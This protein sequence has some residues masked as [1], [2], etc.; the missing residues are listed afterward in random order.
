[1]RTLVNGEKGDE[2]VATGD[3]YTD[4][5]LRGRWRRIMRAG[6][7]AVML[8]QGEERVAWRMHGTC[9]DVYP[10]VF[11]AELM[12]VLNVLRVA[13]PPLKIHV[14]NAEVVSGFQRGEEWCLAPERDGC[15]L[16]KEVW[17]RMR[18]MDGEVEV[19]KVKAHTAEEEVGE[20]VITAR[21][22]YG[23]LHADAE[24][25]RGAR[26]AES[27]SP[28]GAARS[29]FLKAVR[30]L[31]WVRRYA[32][33]WKEDARE[34]EEERMVKGRVGEGQSELR[35]GAGLRHLVWEKGLALTCRRCGRVADTDQKRRDLRSSRCQ[36][37]AVGRL[38]E[39]TCHDV[40]AVER[41]CVERRQD[42][43]SRGWRPRR[44]GGDEAGGDPRM[45]GQGFNEETE[46]SSSHEEEVVAAGEG[47]AA[48]D[49]TAWTEERSGR[50]GHAAA[51]VAEAA[52]RGSASA[53]ADPAG[54]HSRET[55]PRR[56]GAGRSVTELWTEDVPKKK[57]R[58]G[59]SASGEDSAARGCSPRPP[60]R[61]KECEGS[62]GIGDDETMAS[63]GTMRGLDG[64]EVAAPSAQPPRKNR[65]GPT[66]R[67]QPPT[68]R[69]RSVPSHA[70]EAPPATGAS[71]SSEA[72][73]GAQEGIRH[74]GDPVER[75]DEG[76][77]VGGMRVP[78][79]LED[80]DLPELPW[81]VAL[82]V[83]AELA[84]RRRVLPSG[85]QAARGS[86]P[87][88]AAIGERADPGGSVMHEVV[89]LWDEDPFGYVQEDLAMQPGLARAVRGDGQRREGA[90]P[91]A[92][93]RPS[94]ERRTAFG[95]QW[96]E[97][98]DM[99]LMDELVQDVWAEGE[100]RAAGADGDDDGLGG[101]EE[102]VV[103]AGQGQR[104]KRQRPG[105]PMQD[106]T[107]EGAAGSATGTDVRAEPGQSR[108]AGAFGR[109]YTGVVADPVD[110]ADANGHQ[111][112][113]T[114][115]IIFCS[116]CGRYATRRVG[117]ALKSQCGGVAGGAYA[118]RLARMLNGK[119]PI[120]G[121]PIV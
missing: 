34:E 50:D 2:E 96:Q 68:K 109:R 103:M 32:A 80:D 43:L 57:A 92:L 21:D 110:A 72:T 52:A 54:G 65:P 8:K 60:R 13:M 45:A 98:E 93:T 41:A 86:A 58:T 119:H 7:G 89:D 76:H 91:S 95:A 44:G 115:P 87:E 100:G 42:L 11:R 88:V 104:R 40:G 30:W 90:S 97:S 35:K 118:S 19:L 66:A 67:P 59:A 73:V 105:P 112:R 113:V 79:E 106:E 107:G 74:S 75:L 77:V 82:E 83:Q 6:W 81:S 17:E 38:L 84:E 4:G 117:R 120:T 36:G 48:G 63:G 18:E 99:G 70:W 28:V 14:D 20:G 55:L 12:A 56:L 78:S 102:D 116:R 114:G 16:W 101:A 33:M 121:N 111:L 49:H 39:R 108:G 3:V 64:P 51:E 15:E 24:A 47:E 10:S 61:K 69:R 85:H 22:R 1:M 29:E 23:N 46:G 5:A 37:T 31:G 71:C 25:R 53:P 94:K 27:L 26:L 62:S 9:P